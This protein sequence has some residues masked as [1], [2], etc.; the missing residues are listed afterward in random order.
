MHILFI[1]VEIWN[2]LKLWTRKSI[3]ILLKWNVETKFD[4]L[5]NVMLEVRVRWNDKHSDGSTRFEN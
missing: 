3:S 4:F 1:I 2:I 5:Q